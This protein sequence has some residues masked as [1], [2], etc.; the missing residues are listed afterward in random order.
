MKR[1]G[2]V[3]LYVLLC[4]GLVIP[5]GNPGSPVSANGGAAVGVSPATQTVALGGTFSVDVVVD[6]GSYGISGGQVDIQFDPTAMSAD[7]L[8]EGGLLGASPLVGSKLVDNGAGTLQLALGRVG[9]TTPPTAAGVFATITFTGKDKPGTFAI[10]ITFAGMADQ[11]FN[12]IESLEIT[13]GSVTFPG[14]KGTIQVASDPAGAAYT[15]TGPA[16]YSGTATGTAATIAADAPVGDYTIDWGDVTGYVTPANETKTLGDGG[17]ITFSGVYTPAPGTIEVSSSPGGATF[18]ITG[19][20]GY[21]GTAPDTPWAVSTG[22]PPGDYTIAWGDVTGYIKPADE[23]KTLA[24]GGKITFSGVY[25]E[26]PTQVG[27]IQVSSAP[28]GAAYSITGPQNYAGTATSTPTVIATDAPAGN[29]TIVWADVTGY[30]KPTDMTLILAAGG[31]ITFNGIYSQTPG[32]I[33]VS[34]NP[35]G[36]TYS[37]AGSQ[38]YAGTATGTPTA[39]ATDAPVGN[40]GIVWG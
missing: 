24:A 36:A 28:T 19:P 12:D 20:V 23:T 37:I 18:W 22:A 8:V 16:N 7:S 27:T 30:I 2:L 11:G 32:T 25:T 34:S 38:N 9:A 10:D 14:P 21:G 33:E 3:L 4:V 40:Y 31:N 35:S 6:P 1:V 39:I 26:I 17:S 5:M 15:I 13:D 29:Y